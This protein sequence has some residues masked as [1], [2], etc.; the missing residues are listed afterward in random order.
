M[1]EYYLEDAIELT[2]FIAPPR[3]K[4]KKNPYEEDDGDEVTII[5]DSLFTLNTWACTVVLL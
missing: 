3:D 4:K 1:V 2:H 5:S